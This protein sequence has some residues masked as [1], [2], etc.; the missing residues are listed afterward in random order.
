LFILLGPSCA[1]GEFA[2]RS[3]NPELFIL[4]ERSFSAKLPFRLI[5]QQFEMLAAMAR[6][7]QCLEIEG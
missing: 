3:R 1:A 2:L 6:D 7:I 4:A 5:L